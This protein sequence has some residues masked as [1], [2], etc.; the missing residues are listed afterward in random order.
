MSRALEHLL[1]PVNFGESSHGALEMAI[2]LARQLKARLTLVHVY[3]VPAYV[4]GGMT[5]ATADLFAP[6]EEGA[7]T[8]LDA[9]VASVKERAPELAEVRGVLRRGVAAAEILA[10]AEEAHPDSS[11]SWE[12]TG[13]RGCR[14]CCS[15]AWPRR[16]SASPPSPCSRCAKRVATE[17]RE[18]ASSPAHIAQRVP[19]ELSHLLKPSALQK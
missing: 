13:A 1:V 3:E 8:H 12:R 14:A 5:Y 10:V 4:Y 6:I 9:L 2:S 11:S 18:P 17:R 19:F 15:G 7:R 16:W